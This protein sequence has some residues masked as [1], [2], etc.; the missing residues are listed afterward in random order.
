MEEKVKTDSF[1]R[2]AM[3]YGAV[4]GIIIVAYTF[5]LYVTDLTTNRAVGFAQW[6]IMVACIYMAVKRYRDES[7]GGYISYGK[8]LGFGTLTVFFAS[9]IVGFFTYILYTFID[10][11]LIDEILRVSEESL[12]Q[13][14]LSDSEIDAALE[15]TKKFTTPLFITITTIIGISF[16][17]FIF[18]LIVGIFVKRKDDSFEGQFQ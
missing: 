10:P 7:L 6:A 3:F 17:G 16:M 13:Q 12:L 15:M 8:A 1:S 18:S 5:I 2:S 4:V 11:S 14:G 9:L